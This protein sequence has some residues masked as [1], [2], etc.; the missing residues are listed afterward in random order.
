M[1]Y[2]SFLMKGGGD[3]VA[4]MVRLFT[5]WGE[6]LIV[7]GVISTGEVRRMIVDKHWCGQKS[8]H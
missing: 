8:N 4:T 2:L 5:L 7:P 3:S 1:Y 6:Q